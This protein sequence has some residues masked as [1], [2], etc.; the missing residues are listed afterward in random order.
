MSDYRSFSGNEP[1]GTIVIRVVPSNDGPRAFIRSVEDA[2]DIAAE[3]IEQSEQMK[4]E[5]AL[6]LARN[7][8][9]NI[10][11]GAEVVI[12]LAPGANWDAR[13]GHLA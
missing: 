1:S 9:A 10:A 2:Q 3:S 6:A 12:E 11:G 5:E 8:A 13:W 4:V 7:K